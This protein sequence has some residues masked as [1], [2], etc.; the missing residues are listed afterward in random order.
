V[1]IVGGGI[2]GSSIAFNLSFRDARVTLVDAAEPGQAASRVSFAWMNGRDKNPRHY[3]DLNRRS[4]DMWDRFVRRLGGDVG[5]RWGGEMRWAATEAGAKDFVQRVRTLQSW[6]YPIRMINEAEM[7]EKEP[8]FEFGP[9]TA[10]AYTH[11]EGHAD[12]GKV[13]EACL[14]HAK[15]NGVEV[16]TNT[17]VTGLQMG[18]ASSGSPRIEALETDKGEIE[19]DVVVLATGADTTQLAA[20]AGI[21]I[22]HH[23]TFGC[24]VIT[25]PIAPVFQNFAVVHTPRDADPQ[26]NFRQFADGTFMMHGGSHGG[27]EDESMGRTDEDA[28]RVFLSAQ[29]YVPSLKQTRIK[30]IR[31]GRRPMPGDGHPILGFAEAVPNLYFATMHSGVSL[32]A[33]V[34]E[35]AT[36]EIIDGARIDILEHYRVERFTR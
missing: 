13:I 17:N 12:T 32:A 29:K 6:G 11:I 24:T 20:R 8:N 1:V 34:G 26:M 4:V 10:A 31:R 22:S 14:R 23:Y 9:V 16:Q 2:I 25:E 36:T 21:E 27:A 18:R 19:C 7:R 15:A 28:E 35:Y 30:E 5:V 33:L 3:H